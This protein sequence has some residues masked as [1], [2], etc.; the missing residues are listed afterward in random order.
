MPIEGASFTG[1]TALINTV[2]ELDQDFYQT[3][4]EMTRAPRPGEVQAAHSGFMPHTAE[5]IQQLKAEQAVGDFTLYAVHP[6][7]GH[8]YTSK[9]EHFSSE[10]NIVPLFPKNLASLRTVPFASI[11]P[12]ALSCCPSDWEKYY[13]L[14][15]HERDMTSD[16]IKQRILEGRS[17]LAAALE[18]GDDVT[19]VN[20]RYGA[21]TETARSI[22]ALA[23]GEA[24]Q[25]DPK[26]RKMGEVLLRHLQILTK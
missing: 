7:T 5:T 19:W 23:R 20:N 4:G 18:Q 12:I 22:I 2:C 8:V 16:D 10:Y 25:P 24:I 11:T 9:P 15:V 26:A 17:N 21:L 1:K 13:A 3:K 14:A 6:Y